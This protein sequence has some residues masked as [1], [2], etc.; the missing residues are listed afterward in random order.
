M[1]KF[2]EMY[3]ITKFIFYLFHFGKIHT[4]VVDNST[5]QI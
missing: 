1:H 4:P 2:L 3:S 5:C